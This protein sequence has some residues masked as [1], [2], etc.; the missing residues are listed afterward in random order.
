MPPVRYGEAEQGKSYRQKAENTAFRFGIHYGV[1]PSADNAQEFS[2]A[3][4]AN[5]TS[6]LADN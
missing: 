4:R 5:A 3:L 1:S 6:T 2:R